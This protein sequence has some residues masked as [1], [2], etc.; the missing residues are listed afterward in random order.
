MAEWLE[1]ASR[2]HEMYCYDLEVMSS[3]PSWVDLW[4]RSTSVL[5]RT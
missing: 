4:V 1:Q 5:S 2:W 3:N